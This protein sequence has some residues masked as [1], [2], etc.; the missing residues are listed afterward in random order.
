MMT[1]LQ[2]LKTRNEI[3][4]NYGLLC[5]GLALVFLI[6]TRTTTV[7]VYGVNAWY[8]PFKFAFSTFLFAWAMAWYCYYLPNFNIHLFNWSVILL[9]GFEIVYIAI[10]AGKGQISHYNLS[11]PVYSALFSLMALAATLVTLYTAYIGFLF[12]IHSFPDLPNHYLWA[13][14]LSLLIFVVFAFEGFAMGSRLSHTV[15]AINDNSNWFII[16]W[17]KTVGDLRVAHFIGMHALQVLPVLSFYL[18]KN[19]KAT[20][21]ISILYGLLAVVTLVQA[22]KGQPLFTTKKLKNEIIK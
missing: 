15:G 1:F 14:R 4:F 10:M 17:S 20:I 13:I 7:Q 6:L 9:L 5:L 3:L 16:G 12:F 11:T 8:K 21:I 2:E 18:L 22:L 19:T